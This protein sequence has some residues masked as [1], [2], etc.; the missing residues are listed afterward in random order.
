[1]ELDHRQRIEKLASEKY[2]GQH[3]RIRAKEV[4]SLQP[5]RKGDG[6][7]AERGVETLIPGEVV[8]IPIEHR[9]G[10]Q[11]PTALALMEDEGKLERVS[12]KTELTEPPGDDPYRTEGRCSSE[13]EAEHRAI[14]LGMDIAPT[15]QANGL[16][17]ETLASLIAGAVAQGV[18]Q[19]LKAIGGVKRAPKPKA[20]APAEA[21]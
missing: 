5:I 19:A 14:D 21:E 1:M 9:N 2:R 8:D 18:E 4:V 16:D 7:E 3:V 17:P 6:G 10:Y 12:S 15:A 11:S 13:D 20:E